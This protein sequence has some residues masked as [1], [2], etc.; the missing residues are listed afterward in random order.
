MKRLLLW[1]GVLLAVVFAVLLIPDVHWRVWGSLRG[2]AFS[3][4]RPTSYWRAWMLEWND[5]G[6]YPPCISLVVR[7]K[8]W[9][10]RW[11]FRLQQLAEQL[12]PAPKHPFSESDPAAVPVLRELSRDADP[13]IR[14]AAAETLAQV[15]AEAAGVGPPL[16]DNDERDGHRAD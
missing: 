16:R 11:G 7:R 9:W 3:R 10:E 1:T 12:G 5:L 14:S 4:R 8:S 6:F 13:E 15:G 2:E